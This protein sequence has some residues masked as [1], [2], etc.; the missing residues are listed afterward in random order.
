VAL[1]PHAL[2]L[3]FLAS[4]QRVGERLALHQLHDERRAV[5]RVLDVVDGCD[6]RVVE[7]GE[8][9]CLSRDAGQ[10]LVISGDRRGQDL[11]CHVASK[12]RIAR[13]PHF[14]HPALADR[15]GDFIRADASA[16]GQ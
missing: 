12:L 6:V 16:D 14:S 8:Q 10:P 13:P 4:R 2:S 3:A 5:R 7:R 15:G 1:E 11:D 9:L